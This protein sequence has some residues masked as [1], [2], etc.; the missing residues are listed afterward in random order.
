[1]FDRISE[2]CERKSTRSRRSGEP[3]LRSS[4]MRGT[5]REGRREFEWFQDSR[6][7]VISR[8]SGEG[9]G[10]PQQFISCVVI[11][12]ASWRESADFRYAPP[13]LA[14]FSSL[15]ADRG[16]EFSRVSAASGECREPRKY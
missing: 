15:G 9:S 5:R 16:S 3:A 14:I 1:M 2:K 10:D 12:L 8:I 6:N 4:E 13:S 7:R 11:V